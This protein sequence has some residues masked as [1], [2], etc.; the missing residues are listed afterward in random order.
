MSDGLMVARGDMGVEIP[1][2]KVPMVQKDLIRQ[3]NKLGKPVITATQMLDSMQRNPRATRAEASDVANAIYDGT[4]AVMLS[5]ETAAGLYPEEAVKTMRNIAVSAE[6]AQD[7]KKLLSDRTKLVETS[8]VNAIGISVA[9]TALNLN[10]KAI[11]AATESGSTAR[12]I[13]KYRPHSDIIAV[14][15]SEETARQCSIV[16]ESNL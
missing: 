3:C 2:E 5:G 11:V 12:T 10:V 16:W 6:A 14:T 13:S 8:L 7:Y 4:D 1:P 15:P 9:H